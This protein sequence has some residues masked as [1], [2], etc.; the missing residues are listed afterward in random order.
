M[1]GATFCSGIGAPEIAAPWID[2]RLASEIEQFPREV[3]QHRFGFMD[4]CRHLDGARLWGDFTA[5]KARHF[6]RLNIPFPNIIVAGTPCQSFS[7]AGLRK[8]LTDDR[9]NLTLQFVRTVHA[10]Q[11]ARPDGKLIVLWENVPGVLSDRG[12][13][14]GAFL[15]GMVWGMD[16]LPS[17]DGGSWPRE[18]MVEGPRSRAA[19]SVL[20]AQWFGVAQRRRRVFV[21]FDFGGCCDPA[22]VLFDRD[23]LRGDSP[24]SRETGEGFS[25]SPGH[26]SQCGSHW[27]RSEVQT[28]NN[29]S[30]IDSVM[31]SLP[32]VSMCLN[33]GAM[34]RQDAETET[35]IPEIGGV[36][37]VAHSLRGE[38]FDASEDGTG[39]GIPLV[40]VA[41]QERAVRR[42]TPREAERLQGFPDDHTLIPRDRKRVLKDVED[43]VRYLLS[44]YPDMTTEA[45]MMLAADGPRYKALGNSMA[46]PVIRW[47]M[48]RIRDSAAKMTKKSESLG[49]D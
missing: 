30:A 22:A 29:E 2:W 35:L 8:G 32:D 38:G 4:A 37:D 31:A 42:L 41:I 10:I 7:V 6:R 16:S 19:W 17:P 40:P 3:L 14:F 47:I 15:G 33:A 23:S 1:I 13:A 26:S 20:D 36:V 25:E 12:N 27:D 48:S 39:R 44:E 46:V 24:P 9:G 11:S 49:Q 45:A 5:L 21:V 18:G 34:G 28:L 43:E